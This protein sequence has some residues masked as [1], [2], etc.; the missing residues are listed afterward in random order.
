M[1]LVKLL[2]II[3]PM[4]ILLAAFAYITFGGKKSK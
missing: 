2:W 4:V 1:I 3:V